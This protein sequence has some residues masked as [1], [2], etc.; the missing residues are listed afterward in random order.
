MKT[1][2][3]AVI[4][5][6]VSII[7]TCYN[8]EAFIGLALDSVLSQSYGQ[9]EL[10]IIDNGSR[11]QSVS[12]IHEWTERNR[13]KISVRT[14]FQ[15]K[16]INY[17]KAFNQ[18]LALVSGKYLIDLSG[19]DELLT[20]HVHTAVETLE[21]HPAA[22]Y[23]SNANLEGE[24]GQTSTFYPTNRRADFKVVS[25]DIYVH[26]VEKHLL[27]PPTLVFRTEILKME[28]G[29]DEEL[30]YEDFDIITR[31]ARNHYFTYGEHIGMKK[32]ILKTSFSAKQ[33]RIKN[34][35]MLPSTLKV[36]RKIHLMNQSRRENKALYS[37]VLFEAK[38]ALAS[39]NF[40]VAKEFLDLAKETGLFSL[41]Y[42]FFRFWEKAR[43]D[44]SPIYKAIKL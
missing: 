33:Y 12:L 4:Q 17:C 2:A 19:D 14:I 44:L 35:V 13:A 40:F 24:N 9:I 11:D 41:R 20:G 27:C 15:R 42:L 26:V 22:V 5:P 34:S 7:C 8:H 32:R 36:C 6:L 25:G 28:G 30:A 3:E 38:H 1:S 18:G 10:I 43:W 23:F 37:R 39:G 31:L 29:Y 16:T 21:K